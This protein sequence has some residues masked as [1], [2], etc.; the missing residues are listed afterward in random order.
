MATPMITRRGG[1]PVRYAKPVALASLTRSITPLTQHRRA[2]FVPS[3]ALTDLEYLGEVSGPSKL[4]ECPPASPSNPHAGDFDPAPAS[5]DP[6]DARRREPGVDQL[7][8]ELGLE[9]IG[10]HDRLGAAVNGCLK[11]FERS[12]ALLFRRRHRCAAYSLSLPSALPVDRTRCTQ[13]HAMHS[14]D[15]YVSPLFAD[16]SSAPTA[17]HRY[18]KVA[19]SKWE[20]ELRPAVCTHCRDLPQRATGWEARHDPSRLLAK[21]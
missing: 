20:T 6:L 21:E 19:I 9:T 13:L 16:A 15:S 3:R 11:Q 17:G 14:N 10:Q 7:D 8:Q 4:R 12:T 1:H 2:P 18:V 5:D